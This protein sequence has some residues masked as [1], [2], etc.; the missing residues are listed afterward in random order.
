MKALFRKGACTDKG[1]ITSPME[2]YSKENFKKTNDTDKAC[3]ATKTE[4]C[5]KVYGVRI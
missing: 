1:C 3:F 5:M 4:E 2:T